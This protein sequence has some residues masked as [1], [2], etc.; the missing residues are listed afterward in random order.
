MLLLTLGFCFS[1][2]AE[3]NKLFEKESYQEYVSKNND[4]LKIGDTLIIGIPTSELGFTYISQGGQRVSNT[5]SGKV[6]IIDRLKTY[7]AEKNG[8]K[9]YAQ[10]KGYGLLPVLIDYETAFEVGEIKNLKAKLTMKQV[11]EKLKENRD[12]FDLGVIKSDEYEKNRIELM[13]LISK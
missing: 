3:F 5:L 11:I 4:I 1:Q 13:K 8:F 10:F 12:L 9:M 2:K 7:G 6:I